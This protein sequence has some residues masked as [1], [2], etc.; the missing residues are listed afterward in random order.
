MTK[1]RKQ[2][3]QTTTTTTTTTN[4]NNKQTTTTTTTTNY[5]YNKSR[6]ER[7]TNYFTFSKPYN[8]ATKRLSGATAAFATNSSNE[9]AARRKNR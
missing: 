4:N 6:R 1:N 2:Q 3:Q 8:F 5:N 9:N 7:I